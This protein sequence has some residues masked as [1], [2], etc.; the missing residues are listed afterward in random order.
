MTLSDLLSAF[1]AAPSSLRSLSFPKRD[2]S[3]IEECFPVIDFGEGYILSRWGEISL[4]LEVSFPP[5]F[6]LSP[7]GYSALHNDI[8]DAVK[9]IPEGY[10]LQKLDFFKKEGFSFPLEKAYSSSQKECDPLGHA[11]RDHFEGREYINGRSF[12][13]LTDGNSSQKGRPL[14]GGPSFGKVSSAPKAAERLDRVCS[15]F[16][17]VLSRSG[18]VLLRRLPSE[19]I[20]GDEKC[21]GIIG[22]YLSLLALSPFSPGTLND[23]ILRGDR[24]VSGDKVATAFVEAGA[25][26]FPSFLSPSKRIFPF[27]AEES[28]GKEAEEGLHL[29][30]LHSV[31]YGLT[32]EHMVSTVLRRDPSGE[33]L[34]SLEAKRKRMHALSG[35]NSL[36]RINSERIG[37]FLDSSQKS[38]RI[39]LR[40]RMTVFPIG[41]SVSP[42]ADQSDEAA[43]ALSSIGF[44]PCK[45]SLDAQC[46]FWGSIPGNAGAFPPEEYLTA[47]IPAV[48]CLLVGDSPE[49]GIPEDN[50]PGKGLS[51]C[52]RLDGVPRGVDFGVKAMEKGIV[53]NFNAFVL[54]P[55]GSGKSFFM[56]SFLLRKYMEGSH[57]VIIDLGGSYRN[58]TRLIGETSGGKDGE[59]FDFSWDGDEPPILFAPMRDLSKTSGQRERME[60]YSPLLLTLLRS[61]WDMT[62][63]E[64][65]EYSSTEMEEGVTEFLSSYSETFDPNFDDMVRFLQRWNTERLKEGKTKVNLEGLFTAL[66]PFGMGKEYASLLN[67]W[68]TDDISSNRF[69]VF[70]LDPIKNDPVRFPITLLV[71]I[72]A[73]SRKMKSRPDEFKIMVIEEAWKALGTSSMASF[74][75]ELYKT[76]RKW[77]TSAVTVSQELGDLSGSTGETILEN[78]DTLVLLDQSK[79]MGKSDILSR[80]LSLSPHDLSLIESMGKVGLPSDGRDV[81]LRVG[82]EKGKVLRLEVSPEEKFLFS[83]TPSDR[84]EMDSLLKE[85]QSILS[86]LH[87]KFPSK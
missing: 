49:K 13:I 70:D 53:R 21:P 23:L 71:I 6:S 65:V 81:F 30:F 84:S 62:E 59:Y 15:L 36:N 1:G 54:G 50:V 67:S 9:T 46:E 26:C 22:E 8:C 18:K 38:G 37:E 79:N 58:L 82:N 14:F 29:S 4:I 12:L 43:A 86:V 51:L 40:C 20:F 24:I 68:K 48:S 60:K 28:S 64:A 39:P 25:D 33:I 63:H 3:P 66:V 10:I 47:D 34:S 83:S 19:E 80:T 75:L 35:K 55:S 31:G 16:C 32:G 78:S 69:V 11:F 17:S 57:C 2:V 45:D 41:E 42:S 74:V 56:N 44:S 76:A 87:E 77:N 61:I 27:H 7:S 5:A 73:F 52:G 72:D 85:K